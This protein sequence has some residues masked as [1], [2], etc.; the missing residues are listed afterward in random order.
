[1]GQRADAHIHLFEE[2]LGGTFPDRPGVEMDE[3]ACFDSL[4]K[5]SDIS[6]AL[7]VC[8]NRCQGNG[9]NNEYVVGLQSRYDWVRPAT[10]VEPDETPGIAALERWHDE[11]VVGLTM[12]PRSADAVL[13]CPDEIWEWMISNR[14]LLSVNAKADAWDVWQDILGRHRE[15]RLV[16]SHL[17]LPDRVTEPIGQAQAREKLG[18]VI[19]LSRYPQVHV[20]LSGFYALTEPSY[21]HPYELAWPL[22]EALIEAFSVERL[23]FASDYA[24]CLNH[25][26]YP[27]TLGLFRKMPFLS[28]GD[29]DR[30]TGENLLT[31]LREVGS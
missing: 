18:S 23:L 11:G 5:E 16:I 30:I 6:A 31:L 17:G 10:F 2:P 24:P 28:D 9:A 12:Y 20:K 15:L 19:A 27:Q 22:V 1:M 26:T 8:Y 21:D 7:V 3:A 29:R 25:H 4:A 14:W 13:A